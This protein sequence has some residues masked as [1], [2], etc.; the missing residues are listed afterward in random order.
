[1]LLPI[2]F[3]EEFRARNFRTLL[4][5]KPF[6]FLSIFRHRLG[7]GWS[8]PTRTRTMKVVTKSHCPI[9]SFEVYDVV[10]RELSRIPLKDNQL[11]EE[12]LRRKFCYVAVL[13]QIEHHSSIPSVGSLN[14][15]TEAANALEFHGVGATASVVISSEALEGLLDHLHRS[16]RYF[17]S[18]N[19]S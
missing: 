12:Q 17:P 6:P 11:T 3:A 19:C 10:A 16:V 8:F 5:G 4:K 18:I 7:I 2:V 9:S 14:L 1:M 15:S 13:E